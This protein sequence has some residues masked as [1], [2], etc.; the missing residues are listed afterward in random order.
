M[1]KPANRFADDTTNLKWGGVSYET[2]N[3]RSSGSVTSEEV[4]LAAGFDL[5]AT[6]AVLLVFS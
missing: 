4:D 6:E 3:A 1:L 5:K 2:D